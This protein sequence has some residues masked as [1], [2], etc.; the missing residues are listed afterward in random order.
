VL[1]GGGLLFYYWLLSWFAPRLGLGKWFVVLLTLAFVGQFVAGTVPDVSGVK[2]R[3]H[4]LA[5]YGMAYLFVPLSILMVNAPHISTLGKYF[6]LLC[7]AYLFS[8]WFLFLF[9]PKSKEHY[10]VFQVL[11]VV[12]FQLQILVA[13]YTAS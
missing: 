3:I 6:G 7:L 12:A 4:R 2:R 11:Y 8:G 5:A 10:L 1:N 13:A 9:F